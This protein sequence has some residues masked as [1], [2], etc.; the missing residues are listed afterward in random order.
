MPLFGARVLHFW[1][2]AL[3]VGEFCANLRYRW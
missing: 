3:T 1:V 2:A